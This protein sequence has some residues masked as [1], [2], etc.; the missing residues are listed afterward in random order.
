MIVED[1]IMLGR[2]APVDSKKFGR[3]VCSAGYSR[4]LRQ[5]VRVYPLPPAS[6]VK[7]WSLC[8]IP[9]IRS[10]H[11]NRIESWRLRNNGTND[12]SV[13]KVLGL[14]DKQAEFDYLATLATHI[15]VL[16]DKRQSLGIVRLNDFNCHYNKLSVGEE[17]Q[18]DL[19]WTD[20]DIPVHFRPRIRFDNHDLQL[21][22]WGCREFLR[23]HP[24]QLDNLWD[25]L[26]LTRNDY[27]HL[28]FIGNMNS[29]RTSWQIISLVSRKRQP[30]THDLFAA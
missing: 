13:I 21:L 26:L 11:D 30:I 12:E 20:I 24:K 4:E 6:K 2:T 3:S 28:A 7:K 17:K 22:D 18:Q 8:C 14:A 19:F 27:E 23:K 5:F 9:L 10:S 29:H 15:E 16:N 1:F 25:A